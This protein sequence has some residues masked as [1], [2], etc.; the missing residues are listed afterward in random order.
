M[1]QPLLS[2]VRAFLPPPPGPGTPGDAGRFGPG[3][4]AWRV[5]RE[6]VLLL[7]GPAALLLQVAHPLVA[8][9]VTAHSDFTG[10]PLRRLRGTLD[11]VLTVTFGDREQAHD[12]ARRVGRRHAPVRGA[13]AEEAGP[14][15]AGT[16]YTAHDPALA[17]WVWATL[18]WSALRTTDV[19]VRRVP[20]PER[21]AYV[22]DMHRFGRLFGVQAAVPADAAGLEAYVQAHVEGVLAVGAPARA[23]ADQVLRPQPPLLPRPLRGAPGFLAAA[24]LPDPVRTAYGLP[25]RRRERAAWAML[26]P[27]VRLGLRALP[28]VVRTWPHARVAAA[29]VSASGTSGRRTGA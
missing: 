13:L 21:D 6:R 16:A 12:A 17:Q 22:R 7:A 29:R 25:W 4:A 2:R 10:D 24:L 19:L 15:G 28:A 9:G 14:F 3:T 5:G 8:A 20:D 27:A 18:V 26:R 1:P 23:L 11:A